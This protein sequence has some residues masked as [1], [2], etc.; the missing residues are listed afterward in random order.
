VL[1]FAQTWNN[2]AVSFTALKLNVTDIASDPASMLI[3][4]QVGGAS[5]FQVSRW[6]AVTLGLVEIDTDGNVTLTGSYK[7]IT[8]SMALMLG[9]GARVAI[10]T[11]GICLKSDAALGWSNNFPYIGMPDVVLVRDGANMLAL[12]NGTHGQFFSVY[13]TYTDAANFERLYLQASNSGHYLYGEKAGTGVAQ[14]LQFG[15]NNV[16]RWRIGATDGHWLAVSDNAYDIGADGA[17]RPRHI[18]AGGRISGQL[19]A[20]AA[21]VSETITPNAT[22]TLYDNTGTAYKVPCVAA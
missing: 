13:G 6:G 8:S 20:H 18:Y 15:T 5:Q 11:P 4:L 10:R 22:L 21:A 7:A 3:D 14:F 12:R 16:G 2:A 1:N 17:N 9:E 19:Q